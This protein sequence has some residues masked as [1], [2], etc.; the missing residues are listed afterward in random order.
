MFAALQGKSFHDTRTYFTA[1]ERCVPFVDGFYSFFLAA[2]TQLM[3]GKLEGGKMGWESSHSLW[4][5]PWR[6]LGESL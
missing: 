1:I 6:V 5:W 4:L 2:G 3:C